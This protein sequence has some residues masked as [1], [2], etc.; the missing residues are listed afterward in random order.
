VVQINHLQTDFLGDAAA[1]GFHQCKVG[2]RNAKML[3][4]LLLRQA[5]GLSR[6][7]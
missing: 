3:G 4:G 5:N 7:S 2:L 1:A 6:Q